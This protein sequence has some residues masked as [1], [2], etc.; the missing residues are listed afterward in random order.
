LLQRENQLRQ[1]N[2]IP[3]TY[4]ILRL[5]AERKKLQPLVEEAKKKKQRPGQPKQ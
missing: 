2:F 4:N 1:H 3:L 5:L